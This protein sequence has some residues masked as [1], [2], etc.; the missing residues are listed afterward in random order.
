MSRTDGPTAHAGQK[1]HIHEDQI[2]LNYL[3]K[4]SDYAQKKIQEDQIGQISNSKGADRKLF[5]SLV[6]SL[7]QFDRWE[8]QPTDFF[9]RQR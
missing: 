5:R 7:H 6:P 2:T 1:A 9:S 4:K 8:E 3:K